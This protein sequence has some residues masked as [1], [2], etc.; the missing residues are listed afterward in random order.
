M[1]GKKGKESIARGEKVASLSTKWRDGCIP[2][3]IIKKGQSLGEVGRTFP[4]RGRNIHGIKAVRP[5][6]KGGENW[7]RSLRWKE[8]GKKERKGSFFFSSFKEE[9]SWKW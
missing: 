5:R 1:I 6:G 9:R 4:P 7:R 8:E 3:R 2:E